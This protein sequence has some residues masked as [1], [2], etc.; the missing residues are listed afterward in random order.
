MPRMCADENARSEVVSRL[1]YLI[2]AA[3]EDAAALA[4]AS[5]SAN[6]LAVERKGAAAKLRSSGETIAIVASAIEL[7]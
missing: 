7:L 3:A 4:A 2:T 1:F 5:Q 6:I